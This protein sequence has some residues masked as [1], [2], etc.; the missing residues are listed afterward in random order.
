MARWV[1]IVGCVIKV[2]AQIE[3]GRYSITHGQTTLDALN[4]LPGPRLRVSWILW[5]W[6]LMMLCTIGQLGGI[7][8]GVGQAMAISFPITGDYREAI[9]LPSQ[10]ELTQHIQWEARIAEEAAEFATLSED[11][12]QRVRTGVEAMN[13]RLEQLGQR[14]QTAL[15]TVRAGESLADPWTVDDRYWA[16]AVAVVTCVLLYIGRYGLIQNISTV[17]VVSFTFIT[18][19]NVYALQSNPE[20]KIPLAEW[21]NGLTPQIP[22]SGKALGTALATFGIIG[23]GAAELIFYPYWCMEK[24][25]G[26]F[27]GPRS[28]DDAWSHRARG[29]MRV[30]QI[31]AFVSMIVYTVATLAFFVMGVAVLHRMGLDPD[32]MRMVSTLAESYVPVFGEYAKWLFLVGAIAVLYSTFLVALASQTRLYTDG[33]KI[34]RLIS[35]TDE[36]V[37]ERWISIF[38]VVLPLACLTLYWAGLNPVKAVL[39]S[40]LMQAI[41]L[42]ML[43]FAAIYFRIKR[44]DPRLAPSR[45]WDV[46]L[47]LSS[48]GLLIAGGWGAY[49]QIVNKILPAIQSWLGG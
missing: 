39:L 1:I 4:T 30:M 42:P 27:T 37:H 9:L 49:E 29:W 2:F 16:A 47:G 32:G 28:D 35:P 38:G 43:G 6:L 13:R 10:G 5:Y 8:G 14:G 45:L 21:I 20:W 36:G 12:Q 33:L 15:E 31:D 25:Y 40:G 17:L 7:V 18:V 11:E 23:V 19:G 3:L 34:W 41:M 26:R 22:E 24:G 46:F 44:T 48:L